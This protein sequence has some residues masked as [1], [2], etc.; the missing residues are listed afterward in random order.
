[1]RR[2]RARAARLLAIPAAAALLGGLAVSGSGSAQAT[3]RAGS[4]G[5]QSYLEQPATS[6]VR[7]V[8]ATVLSGSVTNGRGLTSAGHGDATL[9]V[10]SASASASVLLD[11]GVEVE[12]TPYL[13]I[14][15]YGGTSPAVSLAFTEA[16]SYLRTPGSSTLASATTAGATTISVQS[17]TARSPLTFAA[18]DTV[19]VGS[20]SET[21]RIV[22]V[23]GA[24]ITLKTPLASAH[25]AGAA[26]TSTPGAITG[27]S[28]FQ[29]RAVSLTV[30]ANGVLNSGFMGG[31]RFEAITLATPGTVVLRG[32]GLQFGGGYLATA[33]DYQG[34]FL[35]SSTALNAM[36]YDGAYTEQ[37]D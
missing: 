25:L 27:D 22:S 1:H 21:D 2:G 11:Y 17:G 29:P 3:P 15:S 6:D 26:V 18:G 23:S 9:T 10:T 20:P 5:W 19:T 24:V 16:K 12:G 13:D 36:F 37:T 7:A 4:E 28:A 35:S 14:A 34:H 33:P 8:S 30:S 31:F 32:A